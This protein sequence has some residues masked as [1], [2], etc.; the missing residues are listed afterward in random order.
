MKSLPVLVIAAVLATACQAPAG[1]PDTIAAGA[2]PLQDDAA[3]RTVDALATAQ[4]AFANGDTDGLARAMHALDA[5]GVQPDDP[6]SATLL[7]KWESAAPDAPAP[8]RGRALGPAFR[9]GELAAGSVVELEQTFLAGQGAS[10]ALRTHGGHPVALK[11]FDGRAKRLCAKSG[12]RM[13]CRWTPPYT[14]R[15]VIRIDNPRRAAVRYFISF[16]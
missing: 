15:H 4:V 10:I 16:E 5:L 13:A 6:A 8:R 7:E 14:Q 9:S 12:A 3:S 2:V 1:A 11:V